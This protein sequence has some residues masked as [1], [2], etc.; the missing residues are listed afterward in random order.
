MAVTR[1]NTEVEDAKAVCSQAVLYRTKEDDPSL[2]S[3]VYDSRIRMVCF[4]L[5][6]PFEQTFEYVSHYSMQS[7]AGL[8]AE[9]LK[10]HIESNA[11][12]LCR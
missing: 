8:I 7:E 12:V 6:D 4:C 5:C 2:Y 11:T 3:A 1:T 10:T 9:R